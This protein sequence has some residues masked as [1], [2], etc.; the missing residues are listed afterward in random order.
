MK[1]LKSFKLPQSVINDLN[2]P[3]S[4][5]S[6]SSSSSVNPAIDHFCKSS[7]FKELED[8]YSKREADALIKSFLEYITDVKE[9][10][11]VREDFE[12]ED[13][14]KFTYEYIDAA[15]FRDPKKPKA[16]ID[17]PFTLLNFSYYVNGR[18]YLKINVNKK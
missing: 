11:D 6:S 1:T 2:K 12:I 13:F 14:G 5:K 3:K 9:F 8:K 17:D 15:L 4:S 18:V 10:S 7:F 16:N